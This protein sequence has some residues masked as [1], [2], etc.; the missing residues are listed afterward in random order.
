MRIVCVSILAA[1]VKYRAIASMVTERCMKFLEQIVVHW[2][3]GR[4]CIVVQRTHLPSGMTLVERIAPQL[5]KHSPSQ[6]K[7]YPDSVLH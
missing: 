2:S 5:A 7:L 6:V 4:S 3:G 1:L